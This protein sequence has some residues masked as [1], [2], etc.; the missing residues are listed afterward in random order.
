MKI[1]I[2]RVRGIRQIKPKIRKTL[3]MLRLNRPNHCVVVD[4]SKPM[5][6]MLNVVR[7]QVKS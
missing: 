7:D 2:V 6:G 3:E 1:A 5:T 4:D